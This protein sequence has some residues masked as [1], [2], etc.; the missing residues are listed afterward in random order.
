MPL[1]LVFHNDDPYNGQLDYEIRTNPS[2]YVAP[3]TT[4]LFSNPVSCRQN[5]DNYLAQ[6]IPIEM[7]DACPVNQYYYS[8]FIALQTLLDYTKISVSVLFLKGI[9]FLNN[10]SS[11]FFTK[12]DL[13]LDLRL[14]Q[15]LY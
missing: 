10:S 14:F 8:G 9:L 13:V 7:G 12:E 6:M 1:A 5:D 15:F 3:S 4:E 2:F 11:W